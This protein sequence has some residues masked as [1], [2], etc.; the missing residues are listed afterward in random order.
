MKNKEGETIN[1]PIGGNDHCIDAM[2]YALCSYLDNP[3]HGEY[4]VW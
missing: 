1:K 3:N 2:R 4:N